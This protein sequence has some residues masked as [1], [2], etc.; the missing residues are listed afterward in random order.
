MKT[1]LKLVAIA[2][3]AIGL[4][5]NASAQNWI[6]G[7]NAVLAAQS[8][9][10][11]TSAAAVGANKA[12]DIITNGVPRINLPGTTF[13][14]AFLGTTGLGIN[15][16][17]ATIANINSVAGKDLGLYAGSANCLTGPPVGGK[18][19]AAAQNIFLQSKDVLSGGFTPS[20]AHRV[21][22]GE[23][24][25]FVPNPATPKLLVRGG[26]AFTQNA[27]C[28][29]ALNDAD[30]IG[31]VSEGTFGEPVTSPNLNRWLTLGTRPSTTVGY[32]SYGLRTQWDNYA[33]DLAVQEWA[34]T[35]AK[36][37]ALT[38]QNGGTTLNV[39]D[40]N[41]F[42]KTR[43]LIQF[44]NGQLPSGTDPR[45][46]VADFSIV[47]G[48]GNSNFNGNAFI[49]GA[50]ILTSDNRLKKD[51]A[52]MTNSM[53]IINKL[54]PVTYNYKSDEY[55][56]MGLEKGFQYGFLAQD[57]E[58]VLPSHVKEGSSGFKGVNYIM[59]IPILTKAL[60]ET[61]AQMTALTSELTNLKSQNSNLSEQLRSKG[62]I[63]NEGA[64][65]ESINNQFYQNKPNPFSEFTSI[66]YKFTSNEQ[67]QII[68]SDLTGKR[69][70]AFTNLQ[71]T[72][73]V[74]ITKDDLPSA[75]IYLYTLISSN[76]EIIG[77]KQM[78]FEK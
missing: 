36:D 42:S 2:M 62:L 57:I 73:E 27:T 19:V 76:G 70:K 34:G 10:L 38:W 58:K 67:Y 8:N 65:V 59:L 35:S 61:N 47:N 4:N 39:T 22:I 15:T 26:G 9:D 55:P 60:Q 13:G 12:L 45:Y 66:S 17:F 33:G 7:G 56:L 72:G 1:N 48:Q 78:M 54:K 50:V 32:N 11:G 63:S 21:F 5:Q 51:V 3:F 20:G 64:N 29:Q 14:A 49:N 23:S 69:I 46:T 71:N 44:R 53:E 25:T 37:V 16:N 6:Q 18:I 30:N 75:G 74:K 41:F 43:L 77:S 31:L 68:V 28:P 24:T 52:P 40:P